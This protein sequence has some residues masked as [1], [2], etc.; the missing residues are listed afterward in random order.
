MKKFFLFAALFALL[1]ACTQQVDQKGPLEGV[2]KMQH[3]KRTVGDTSFWW[4][5]GGMSMQMKIYTEGCFAFVNL[6]PSEDGE[7]VS[8][9]GGYGTYELKGD[10]LIEKIEIFGNKALIG[11]SPA[12]LVTISGDTLIQ[13]GPIEGTAPEVWENMRYQFKE[14]YLRVE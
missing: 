9:G 3:A 5:A 6:R 8:S 7:G 11:A 12:Y 14:V 2:W 1:A 4:E 10:T 13:E